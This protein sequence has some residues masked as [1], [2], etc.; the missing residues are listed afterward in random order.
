MDPD[1]DPP[2][3]HEIQ[4]VVIEP[5]FLTA[6]I[7]QA[8]STVLAPIVE[9]LT[10]IETE[11]GKINTAVA[12]GFTI[13]VCNSDNE[14]PLN[15]DHGVPVETGEA[16]IVKYSGAANKEKGA[17]KRKRTGVVAREKMN[18]PPRQG[19]KCRSFVDKRGWLSP[20]E[21]TDYS[22]HTGRPGRSGL[23]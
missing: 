6:L 14:L 16:N 4:S 21:R 20:R 1:G 11:M 8:M 10:A 2:T 17:V 18:P 9:R 7:E 23:G 13:N 12:N 22:Q 19:L 5:E 15:H 3:G